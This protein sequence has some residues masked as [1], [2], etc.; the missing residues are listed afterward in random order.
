MDRR[1]GAAGRHYA[2]SRATGV[3]S[4][5]SFSRKIFKRYD[6]GS[7]LWF[8]SGGFGQKS[9]GFGPG[10]SLLLVLILAKQ[11]E[12]VGTSDVV[13]FVWD[14][15]FRGLTGAQSA[16]AQAPAPAFARAERRFAV[17]LG[18]ELNVALKKAFECC[19]E[20]KHVAQGM[21]IRQMQLRGRVSVRPRTFPPV[22]GHGL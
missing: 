21:G 14:R 17:P 20:P 13:W 4:P 1:R 16:M 18:R 19:L 6:L 12:L 11:G 2:G 22:C 9:P 15:G 10:F 5:V 3:V 7:D 8:G